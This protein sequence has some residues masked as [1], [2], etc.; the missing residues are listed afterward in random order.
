MHAIDPTIVTSGIAATAAILSAIIAAATQLVLNRRKAQGD[1][2]KSL[3]VR[4]EING[5]TQLIHSS[6]KGEIG[7]I[8]LPANLSEARKISIEIEH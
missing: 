7:A 4:I 5:E 6:A 2:P 3:T 8:N 1:P